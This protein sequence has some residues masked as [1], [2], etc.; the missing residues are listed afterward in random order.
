[1]IHKQETNLK[2]FDLGFDDQNE[3]DPFEDQE[4][5]SLNLLG[6]LAGLLTIP[7]VFG[8]LIG[9]IWI[10][11]NLVAFFSPWNAMM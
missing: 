6:L 7:V 8:V 2:S 4:I 5:N 9:F 10:I 3:I 11:L 1:M